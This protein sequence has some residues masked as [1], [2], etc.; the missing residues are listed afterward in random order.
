M[1]CREFRRLIP[2]FLDGKLDSIQLEG[3]TDHM[4]ECRACETYL[5]AIPDLS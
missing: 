4:L 3:F 5:L 1:Q 2:L